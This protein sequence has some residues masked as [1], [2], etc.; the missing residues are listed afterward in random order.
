[1]ADVDVLIIG[2]G[3]AG[4]AAA[5]S[6]RRAGATVRV[7]E[8]SDE[9]GGQFWRHLPAT[10]PA[11]DEQ[12]L[13]HQWQRY[14]Q[15]RSAVGADPALTVDVGAHVW[16]IERRDDNVR[17][18]IVC[19]DVDG[20]GRRRES[21]T[22]NGL[23]LATGAHDRALPVPGWT[24]PGVVTAGAA[25]AMAKGERIAI[26]ERVVIAGT[27]PFLFP[28]TDSVQKSGSTVVGVYEA[29]GIRRLAR[30][31]LTR[32]WE[33]RSATSKMAE[34]AGYVGTHLRG[35]IPY[36][37]GWGVV[38]INGTD[39]VE[40]ATVARLDEQW[41]PVAGTE[42]I[43]ECDAVCLGHGFTP[44]LELAIAAGCG[45][46]RDRFVTVDHAQRT[47]VPSVFAAGEITGI[48]GVDL[49]L[50]EGEIAGWVA[51]GGAHTDSQLAARGA[52]PCGV[53]RDSRAGS[54]TRTA[55]GRGG[56]TGSNRRRWSAAAKRS[57]TARC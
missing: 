26:G 17:V 45:L 50:A 1:M 35:R 40:S 37:P 15:L 12:R 33:L 20:T 9:S 31:W 39:R 29:A 22:A 56:P 44:R 11:D 46:S 24:L 51:A 23:I 43:V 49:A 41:R 48:G 38:A 55:S 52:R 57:T 10:R 16:T 36:R 54:P 2:A 30:H 6:A 47:S 7:L 5:T 32:P 27:G 34:L 3:P 53:R 28:V 14:Q 19:G 18:N 25:Q 13:H 8:A 21:V 4:L 42:R